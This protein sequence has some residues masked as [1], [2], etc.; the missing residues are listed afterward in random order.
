MICLL[1]D[2]GARPL[3]GI[4]TVFCPIPPDSRFSL[5][6][7][8]CKEAPGK[9]LEPS[10][11]RWYQSYTQVSSPLLGI[12]NSRTSEAS[13]PPTPG[14]TTRCAPT[15]GAWQSGPDSPWLSTGAEITSYPGEPPS[16]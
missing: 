10:A 11:S 1:I 16:S 6:I 7:R 5:T 8:V 14:R 12:T 2:C 13:V 3:T 4:D 9:P 15:C